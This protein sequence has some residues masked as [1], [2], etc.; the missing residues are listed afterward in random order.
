[1]DMTIPERRNVCL[2]TAMGLGEGR[3]TIAS[4][5][6]IHLARRSRRQARH[7]L[8]I[9]KESAPVFR[10]VLEDGICKSE[11]WLPKY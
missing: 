5:M 2:G 7:W 1:M 10:R 4:R 11:Y 6:S 8:P 3:G 9:Q